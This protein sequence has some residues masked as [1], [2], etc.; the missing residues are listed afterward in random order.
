MVRV[1]LYN[2]GCKTFESTGGTVFNRTATYHLDNLNY[3]IDDADLS[4]A[5]F[6][7][8]YLK[9]YS[10]IEKGVDLGDDDHRNILLLPED[11]PRNIIVYEKREGFDFPELIYFRNDNFEKSIFSWCNL[12][13]VYFNTCNFNA[14][15][16]ERS[17]FSKCSFINCIFS[18]SHMKQTI[19][20]ECNF[21]DIDFTISGI[22]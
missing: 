3:R 21:S 22:S 20:A 7:Y 2:K 11:I 12:S 13:E 4:Q 6:K 19:F 9:G 16:F 17:S 1:I 10:N 5:D 18:Y 8:L 14:V 15:D